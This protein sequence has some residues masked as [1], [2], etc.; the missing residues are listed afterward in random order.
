MLERDAGNPELAREL[1]K[2]AVKADPKSEPSWLV[3]LSPL[4]RARTAGGPGRASKLAWRGAWPCRCKG[5]MADP[6]LRVMTASCLQHHLYT[7]SLL[8]GVGPERADCVLYT[9]P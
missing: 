3:S 5:W 1:F 4:L 7:L 2:C 6:L 8:A 9:T